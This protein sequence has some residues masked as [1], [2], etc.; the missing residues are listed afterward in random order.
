MHQTVVFTE[1]RSADLREER[2]LARLVATDEHGG[3]RYL[4][5]H[6]YKHETV[7]HKKHEYV[8]GTVG[9]NT[10][11]TNTIESFW[12]LLKR[13]ILGWYHHVSDAYLPLYLNE[14]AFRFNHRKDS[15]MFEKTLQTVER[16]LPR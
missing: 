14:F 3:Y 11:E 13:G 12:S 5:M 4:K 16:T 10:I 1:R 15:E 6:G 2:R 8:V 9:T 7:N